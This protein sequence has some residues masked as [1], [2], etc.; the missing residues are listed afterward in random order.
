MITVGPRG[1]SIWGWSF[2]LGEEITGHLQLPLISRRVRVE[3]SEKPLGGFCLVLWKYKKTETNVFQPSSAKL[4]PF[5]VLNVR[6]QIDLVHL[7]PQPNHL[8]SLKTDSF[9]CCYHV[10]MCRCSAGS[11]SVSETF[12]SRHKGWV[13]TGGS[14]EKGSWGCVILIPLLWGANMPIMALAFSLSPPPFLY[15]FSVSLISMKKPWIKFPP[16]EAHLS[17]DVSAWLTPLPVGLQTWH[18]LMVLECWHG[19]VGKAKHR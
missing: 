11:Y 15:S 12:T 18:S 13:R 5:T 3:P 7:P 16:W 4:C 6:V 8:F 9:M 10:I 14:V 19:R 2:L 1:T 17:G